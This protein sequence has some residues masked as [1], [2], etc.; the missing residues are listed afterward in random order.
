MAFLC[1]DGALIPQRK[2][3]KIQIKS[4]D[5]ELKLF[6][7]CENL[8]FGFFE[9]VA[10]DS[11]DI[12]GPESSLTKEGFASCLFYFLS[13]Q[14]PELSETIFEI[15]KKTSFQ[16]CSNV[17]WSQAETLANSESLTSSDAKLIVFI[18]KDL[19]DMHGNSDWIKTIMIK[20]QKI[21]YNIHLQLPGDRDDLKLD[22]IDRLCGI[23]SLQDF[24][25]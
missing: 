10:D 1:S 5:F 15:S 18:K 13:F 8:L 20:I 3:S 19:D 23:E 21:F 2:S 16:S 12:D 4:S 11:W 25:S 6:R 17:D 7:R 9:D 24:E 14:K 22:A